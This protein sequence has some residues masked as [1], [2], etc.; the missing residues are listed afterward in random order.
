M[1]TTNHRV[2]V[3]YLLAKR[4]TEGDRSL[5]GLLKIAL[6]RFQL[7]ALKM[8]ELTM[9]TY[10]AKLDR[11][12]ETGF[13]KVADFE[14]GRED[15]HI[16]DHLMQ[17]VTMFDRKMDILCFKDTGRQLQLNYT[18]GET[19]WTLFG[20]PENWEG[21]TITLFLA[22]YNKDGKLGIRV[23]AANGAALPSVPATIERPNLDDEIPF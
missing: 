1:T 6:R 11:M 5:R 4:G 12:K 21:K 15:T 17:D 9:G 2:F 3:V 8:E 22:P 10:R 18:N 13:Y 23:K 14:E 16:I 7:R 20:E 19:L